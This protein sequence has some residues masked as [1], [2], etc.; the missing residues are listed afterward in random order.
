MKTGMQLKLRGLQLASE[1]HR[2]ALEYARESAYILA[3]K[4]GEV[5][6]D[7]VIVSDE[8]SAALGNAAGAIFREKH[9]RCVGFRKSCRPSAHAR[10]IRVWRLA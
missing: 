8:I 6:S 3:L 9:W 2:E 7:D 5:T 10:I 1:A 4:Q